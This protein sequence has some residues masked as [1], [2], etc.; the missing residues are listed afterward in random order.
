MP[1]FLLIC[2]YSVEAVYK[3]DISPLSI[4]W[5]ANYVHSQFLAYLHFF[6]VSM[7]RNFKVVSYLFFLYSFFV[8]F[9]S[10]KDMLSCPDVKNVF[11]YKFVY[12]FSVDMKVF[13]PPGLAS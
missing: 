5:V 10:F 7:N 9:V 12:Y 13:N 4:T 6:H 3:L 11:P 8:S 1:I 2:C